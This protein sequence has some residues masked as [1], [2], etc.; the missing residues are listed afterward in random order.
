MGDLLDACLCDAD[1]E[2]DNYAENAM[3]SRGS[4]SAHDQWAQHSLMVRQNCKTPTSNQ[5]DVV[6]I[7]EEEDHVPKMLSREKAPQAPI[8][9]CVDGHA[10][11]RGTKR[12]LGSFATKAGKQK[13]PK[14]AVGC[15]PC[16]VDHGEPVETIRI[17][18]RTNAVLVPMWSQYL[19][20]FNKKDVESLEGIRWISV[21][22]NEQWMQN[23]V[24]TVRGPTNSSKRT[25]NAR[26]VAQAISECFHQELATCLRQERDGDS[27]GRD[28]EQD[29]DGY[30]ALAQ[31]RA[32]DREKKRRI[33]MVEVQIG[34]FKVQTLNTTERCLLKADGATAKF[35]VGWM[36]PL[37]PVL[38]KQKQDGTFQDG[39]KALANFQFTKIALPNRREKVKWIPHEQRWEI[40]VQKP[41]DKDY[42][43]SKSAFCV[44][45]QSPEE[46]DVQRTAQY[47]QACTTWNRVDG[48]KRHRI[49]MTLKP[50]SKSDE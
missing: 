28:A 19:V 13:K 50:F 31:L 26:A 18:K 43:M 48:S 36:V 8:A 32:A 3:S 37:V 41:K 30:A 1:A 40:Y 25:R 14:S 10:S 38:S 16:P 27:Q 21:G 23:M 15:K 45:A 42:K 44:R 33:A 49:P 4:G 20:T 5:G 29:Y 7:I 22:T 12:K 46:Y 2:N 34:D 39:E 35:I 24:C 11:A 47:W 6:E 9:P 17:D